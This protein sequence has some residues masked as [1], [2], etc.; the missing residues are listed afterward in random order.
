MQNKLWRLRSALLYSDG[1]GQPARYGPVMRAGLSAYSVLDTL[2]LRRK[3]RANYRTDVALVP[4]RKLLYV[5]VPKAASRSLLHFLLG[6]QGRNEVGPAIIHKKSLEELFRIRPEAR[7]YF[8]FT[9]VRNPWSR[10]VSVYNQKIRS[11]DPFITARLLKGRNGLSPNMPFAGFVEW[12]C[13]EEGGDERADK[14]WLSQH[15]ILGIGGAEPVCYDFIGKLERLSGDLEI[16]SAKTGISLSGVGHM[17]YSG[18]AEGYRTVYTDR[19]TEM[20]ARRYARDIE[21]FG[22]RFGGGEPSP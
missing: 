11:D 13:A 19:T 22:Y 17:L 2:V 9:V 18:A 10:V 12:L 14:H 6:Q 5:A 4:G 7:G 8:K 20:V 21:L 15:K 16:L 3:N 1:V